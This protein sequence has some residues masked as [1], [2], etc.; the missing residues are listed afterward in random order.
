[1]LLPR[2]ARPLALVLAWAC[3]VAGAVALP[4]ADARA[5]CQ[6]DPAVAGDTV[7]CTGVDDVDG[8]DAGAV[9][10]LDVVVETGATVDNTGAAA[11]RLNDENTVTVQ[12]GGSVTAS[13]ANARGIE[14][15]D[16]NEPDPDDMMAGD[17]G[18]G[19]FDGIQIDGV[20]T[21]TGQDSVGVLGGARNQVIVNGGVTAG[22]AGDTGTAGIRLGDDAEIILNT[23]GAVGA[24]GVG[25]V[26]IEIGTDTNPTAADP[27]PDDLT[28]N[29]AVTVDGDGGAAT[30][31]VAGA[32]NEIQINLGG[33]VS[34]TSDT[35]VGVQ[36]DDG[37]TLSNS[38][39]I[40]VIGTGASG[41]GVVVS[42]SADTTVITNEFFGTIRV[43]EDAGPAIDLSADPGV[44]IN[45]INNSGTIDA[46]SATM[47]M[48]GTAILGSAGPDHVTNE[49]EI[50]GDVLLGGGDDVLT[51]SPNH[52]GEGLLDGGTESDGLILEGAG[53]GSLDLDRVSG[54]ETLTIRDGPWRLSGAAALDATLETGTL[55]LAETVE[56]TGDFTTS[57]D[58]VFRVIH[59]PIAGTNGRLNVITGSANLSAS[60]DA[61]A[62]FATTPI[63]AP[64]TLLTILDASAGGGITDS[65]DVIPPDTSILDYELLGVG[66]DVL[67]LQITRSSY[68]SVAETPNQ[69]STASYLD[70]VLQTAGNG[71]GVNAALID[72]D[73]FTPAQLLRAY[74]F[75]HPEAYDAHTG[76]MV[77]LGRAFADAAAR[78]RLLCKPPFVGLDPGPHPEIPCGRTGFTAWMRLL[79]Q[80][81]DRDAGS[82]FFTSDGSS[83]AIA[84]GFD[85]RPDRRVQFGGYVGIG[86]VKLEVDDV[87]DGEIQ[88]VEIGTHV[89]ARLGGARIRAA[90][91]YGRGDHEQDRRGLFGTADISTE[92][93]FDSNRVYG[94]LELGWEF[95]L[96]EFRIEPLFGLDVAWLAEDAF[97]EEDLGG[98]ELEVEER[99][100]T[101]VSTEF[102][103]RILYRHHQ[104]AYSDSVIPITQ[105]T[106]TPEIS[107]RW[108]STWVGADRE[109][110]ARLAGAGP[111]AGSFTVD[112]ED[113][114]QGVDVGARLTFQ[115]HGSG[116]SISV[117]YDGFFGDAGINHRFGAEI[118]V[119]F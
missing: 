84:G 60:N 75:L 29:G 18:A 96:G 6:P 68:T 16:D 13:G 51:L 100:N 17:D 72:L 89:H 79:I 20:V 77:A 78:P 66:G 99:E 28:I 86:S 55:D 102:G 56:I 37:N 41:G 8:F 36:L 52:R 117:G 71:A 24:T 48:V 85:W 107:A 109:L 105:G 9:D 42:G 25:A 83:Q 98:L 1:M 111:G 103:G 47:G 118:E 15:G 32:D 63:T 90:F 39:T 2:P 92:G 91:G 19:T 31:V 69:E 62:L 26:G 46:P 50:I 116:G 61:L 114:E 67:Q 53:A 87:G 74:D 80:E 54:F 11:I 45:E 65:F 97:E 57:M 115:P 76:G 5:D 27:D 3:A 10:G 21:V 58:T 14:V 108:R 106:W 12:T 4:G 64:V 73:G 104:S 113:S 23:N 43:G 40:E 44:G 70:R 95:A 82:D 49:F 94:L 35:G 34:V 38:G 7:T 101:I 81:W 93:E 119:Y 33:S 59:D 112:S 22:Q 110:D 88:T 30:G